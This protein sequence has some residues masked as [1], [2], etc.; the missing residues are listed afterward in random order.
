MALATLDR[1]ESASRGEKAWCTWQTDAIQTYCLAVVEED[2]TLRA[3]LADRVAA[4]T[5]CRIPPQQVVADRAARVAFL[6]FDGVRFRLRR[7][8]VVLL[9]PCA[10]CGTGEFASDPLITR[11]DLGHALG[12]WRPLHHGCEEQDRPD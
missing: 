5:A 7:H 1:T 10:H 4:L 2:S 3:E 12:V 9:R 8:Q 6:A 11:G